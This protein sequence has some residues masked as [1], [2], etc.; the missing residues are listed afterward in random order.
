MLKV[1]EILEDKK[2]KKELKYV[3]LAKCL[4]ITKQCF[5]KHLKK[6]KKGK[7]SFSALQIQKICKF[8]NEDVSIFFD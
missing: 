4:G 8:L 1:L 5:S 3:E 7:I 2:R 6:L